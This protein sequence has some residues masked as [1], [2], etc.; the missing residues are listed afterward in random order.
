M[1]SQKRCS[2]RWKTQPA[3]C[4]SNSPSG[5]LGN[6]FVVRLVN[7]GILQAVYAASR[8]PA[9]EGNGYSATI[10]MPNHPASSKR[11][12]MGK[13]F[14]LTLK[15]A[16][17][18]SLTEVFVAAADE[19]SSDEGPDPASDEEEASNGSRPLVRSQ[20]L[21]EEMKDDEVVST[22]RVI[23]MCVSCIYTLR[24]RVINLNMSGEAVLSE[25]GA[26]GSGP[27]H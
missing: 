13:L 4:S 14:A 23:G 10:A 22:P 5:K 25:I 15:R 21:D 9:T 1:Q 27:C 3:I 12:S 26:D 20:T 17:T 18:G 6:L 2:K 24:I 16:S 7:Y 19:R 8:A 11:A